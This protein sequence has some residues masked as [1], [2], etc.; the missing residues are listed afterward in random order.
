MG[1][2]RHRY[3]Y[4]NL[5]EMFWT[6][7]LLKVESS[8]WRCQEFEKLVKECTCIHSGPGRAHNKTNFENV[9]KLDHVGTLMNEA[10]R[11]LAQKY[12]WAAG[13]ARQDLGAKRAL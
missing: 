2:T 7:A 8:R 13:R 11:D 3:L 9:K 6:T 10:L 4:I 1:V 12:D 5:L